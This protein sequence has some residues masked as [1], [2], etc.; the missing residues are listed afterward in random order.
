MSDRSA[1]YMA[2]WRN[3]KG[4]VVSRGAALEELIGIAIDGELEKVIEEDR[5]DGAANN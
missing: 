5:R 4:E 1:E 2:G 3:S